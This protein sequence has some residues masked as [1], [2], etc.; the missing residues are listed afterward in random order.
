[1]IEHLVE[2]PWWW[3]ALAVLLAIGEIVTPGVFL[4]WIAAAAAIT[5]AFA[6]LIPAPLAVQ[7]VLFALLCLA[8]VWFG[9]RWYADNPVESQDPMLNDRSARLV[10]RPVTVVEPIVNG[11]GR[12]TVDDGT[13]SAVG[14][15]APVGVRLTVTGVS[16]S[17]LTVDW[18]VA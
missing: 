13:W 6:M 18:P 7:F 16:G 17:T 1:M 11:E 9:R 3:L 4:I 10:G 12:V 14:P 5:G 15:D 8:A 2:N